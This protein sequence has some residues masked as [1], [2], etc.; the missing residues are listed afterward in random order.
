MSPHSSTLPPAPGSPEHDRDQP[1][2]ES[3]DPAITRRRRAVATAGHAGDE[4]AARAA[5]ADPTDG[6]R[7]TALGALARMGRL[8][9]DDVAG[10]LADSAAAV[11]R[12]AAQ[13][14]AAVDGAPVR[15]GLD[16]SD[17]LVVEMAAWAIGEQEDEDA[18]VDLVGVAIGHADPR[19]REAAV[20]A[21]GA[22]GHPDGL[23]AVLAALSD[24]PAVRRRA[25]VSLA[26]FGGAE[27]KTAL[28]RCLED[29][30]WQVRQVAEELL[31][32]D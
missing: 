5:L 2:T 16:D 22:I 29:R 15:I 19:C 26:A 28:Q 13:T 11:R 14:G 4:A 6:V 7:A 24:R 3:F 8:T 32:D 31:A 25:A 12:R 23:P 21:L 30:D 17:A 18:V 1:S 10:G 9:V 27:V 20:A